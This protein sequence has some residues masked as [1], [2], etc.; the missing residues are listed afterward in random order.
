MQGLAASE[1]AE[2]G[3]RKRDILF[4][5]VQLTLKWLDLWGENRKDKSKFR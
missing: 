1:S 2:Q 3:G 5:E 4:R